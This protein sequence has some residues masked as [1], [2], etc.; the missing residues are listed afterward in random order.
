MPRCAWRLFSAMGPLLPQLGLGKLGAEAVFVGSAIFTSVDPEK[1]APAIALATISA[2]PGYP[3]SGGTVRD[4]TRHNV[5][6][7]SEI[8]LST[9]A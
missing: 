1:R 6:V 9:L 7:P 5:N 4:R 8:E 2:A 3:S